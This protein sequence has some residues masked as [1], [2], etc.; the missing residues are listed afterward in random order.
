[1]GAT[2]S[3]KPS[4][5]GNR[6]F[7]SPYFPT[8]ESRWHTSRP[9]TW[10]KVS[11]VGASSRATRQICRIRRFM[12][13]PAMGS[14][15]VSV[16]TRAVICVSRVARLVAD[17]VPAPQVLERLLDLRAG[18]HH[19]GSMPGDR[20]SQRPGRREEEP[21]ALRSRRCLDQVAVSEDHQG[22][23]TRARALGTEADLTVVHI[24]ER[25]VPSRHAL[26]KLGAGGEVHVDE[27]RR[28]GQAF[29]RPPQA[30]LG[31]LARYDARSR[32]IVQI[33]FR[34]LLRLE[35]AILWPTHLLSRGQIEPQLEPADSLGPDLRHLLV[36]NAAARGHPLNVTRADAAPVTKGVLVLDLPFPDKGD[37]LDAA[38]RMIGKARLIVG[39][40]GRLEM[41]EEQERV[42][43]VQSSSPDAAA[44][45]DAR[46]LDDGLR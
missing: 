36:E 35:V 19:E 10:L 14:S 22:R 9:N 44:K 45:M 23:R 15:E 34:Q 24:G 29:H 17:E 16:V 18:I 1:M 5:M 7:S 30:S 13:R 43:V 40:I 38:V 11:T 2:T 41:V 8:P 27:L 39:G 26:V 25:S 28:D 31:G 46:P 32:S 37:R 4:P 42:E 33:G 12:G 20:L 3:R 21:A 6:A